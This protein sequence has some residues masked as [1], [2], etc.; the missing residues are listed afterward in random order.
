MPDDRVT[1]T[2]P[3]RVGR[4][5]RKPGEQVGVDELGRRRAA[6]LVARGRATGDVD[7]DAPEGEVERAGTN[8]AQLTSG[9]P[10]APSPAELAE[11]DENG[12]DEGAPIGRITT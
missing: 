2:A 8:R 1:L 4:K 11:R 9:R 10:Q 7:E 3:V 6:R 5:E 12:G